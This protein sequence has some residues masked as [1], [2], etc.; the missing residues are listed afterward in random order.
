MLAKNIVDSHVHTDNSPDARDSL[1]KMCEQAQ[2]IGL[3]RFAVT[4]HCEVNRTE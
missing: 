3:R 4:D 1:I 2:Q